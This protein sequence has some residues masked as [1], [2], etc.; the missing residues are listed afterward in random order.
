MQ[1]TGKP[2]TIMKLRQKLSHWMRKLKPRVSRATALKEEIQFWRSWFLSGGLKWPQ[3]FHERF[4]PNQPIQ[5]HVAT[6]IDRIEGNPVRILDVGS[7]PMTKLGK[8]HPSREVTITAT[9]LLASEYDRLL[10]ELGVEPLVR[11]IFANAEK[12]VEQFGQNTFDIVH[13]QNSIDHTRHPQVAIMQMLAVCKPQGYVILYHAENEGQTENYH[14][15]HKWN[16]TCEGGD[17]IIRDRRGRITNVTKELAA[18]GEV[19][20]MRDGDAIHSVI[21]KKAN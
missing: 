19:A 18:Y 21:H 20:C 6:Y 11:T 12:L 15:L 5:D 4:N 9:D 3:D 8:K 13:A 2:F 1:R 17:F 14:Q 16:F 10:S 7:G